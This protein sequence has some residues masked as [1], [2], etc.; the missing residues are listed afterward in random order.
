[1]SVERAE[2]VADADARLRAELRAL[3]ECCAQIHERLRRAHVLA[4]IAT[5]VTSSAMI[6][7]MAA[8]VAAAVTS[9]SPPD[10]LR[11]FA[12]PSGAL[13][14]AFS[15]NSLAVE[16][17]AAIERRL[18]AAGDRLLELVAQF[19]NVG[20]LLDDEAKAGLER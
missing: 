3:E 16:R 1:M 15:S 4:R 13:A 19:A 11:A 5:T 8:A 17:R 20:T 10:A 2:S 12:D 7:P 18:D 14:F 9:P 6:S